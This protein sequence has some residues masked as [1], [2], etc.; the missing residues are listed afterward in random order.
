MIMEL[1]RAIRERRIER[2]ER[3]L[4]RENPLLYLRFVFASIG[5]DVSDLSDEELERGIKNAGKLLSETLPS[6]EEAGRSLQRIFSE[7]YPEG[8]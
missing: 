3:K 5:H 7:A 2:A 1:F 8:F 6:L 4:A